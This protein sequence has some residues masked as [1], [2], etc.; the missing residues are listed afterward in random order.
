MA[1][2]KVRIGPLLEKTPDNFWVLRTYID[3]TRRGSRAP[4][5]V[6]EEFRNATK[7]GQATPKP[8]ISTAMR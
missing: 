5:S 6:I 3:T 2:R 8:G 4:E 7:P 1:D